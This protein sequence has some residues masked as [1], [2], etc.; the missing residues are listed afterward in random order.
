MR[1]SLKKRLSLA[2]ASFAAASILCAEVGR[3]EGDS[4]T[5]PWRGEENPYRKTYVTLGLARNFPISFSEDPLDPGH[6]GPIVGYLYDLDG[7][8][9][10]GVS[11]QFKVLRREARGKDG[12]DTLAIWT[13]THSTFYSVRLDHP[14]YFLG[15]LKI[16]YLLPATRAGAPVRRSEDYR[17]E[18]GVAASA[19]LV[20]IVDKRFI[21]FAWIDRWRGTGSMRLHGIEAGFGLGVS[22][23]PGADEGE[24]SR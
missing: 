14:L 17:S 10:M 15:G 24:A 4:V 3:G 12:S 20:R 8:W 5:V 22:L 18:I 11:G 21:G 16:Q 9:I 1:L 6:F 19:S 2:L 23:G 7:D 13:V